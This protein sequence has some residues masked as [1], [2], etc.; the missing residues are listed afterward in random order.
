MEQKRPFITFPKV[1]MRTVKTV[2][3]ATLVA[4]VYGLINDHT[5]LSVDGPPAGRVPT[6]GT[7]PRGKH[8]I[9]GRAFDGLCFRG[10]FSRQ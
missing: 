9:S 5:P 10:R 6:E 8:S 3:S 2:I 4:I 7:D 1:G